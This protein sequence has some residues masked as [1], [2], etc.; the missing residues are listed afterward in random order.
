MATPPG[1]GHYAKRSRP[2]CARCGGVRCEPDHVIV[3]G[4]SLHGLDLAA[5]I[6]LRPGDTVWLE[7]PGYPWARI[8]LAAAGVRPVS[9]A[10]DAEGLAI[11]SRRPRVNQAQ[12]CNEVVIRI[13]QHDKPFAYQGLSG[14]E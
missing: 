7:E 10:V 3:V 1:I 2:T 14:F 12:A 4:G 6:V 5:R 8:T 9:V 13:R 11:P